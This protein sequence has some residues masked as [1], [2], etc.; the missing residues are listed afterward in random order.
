MGRPKSSRNKRPSLQSRVDA[1]T[2]RVDEATENLKKACAAVKIAKEI[3]QENVELKT[4]LANLQETLERER[5]YARGERDE[6]EKLAH[7]C[8]TLRADRF[9]SNKHYGEV[10]E[11]NIAL[12]K[13]LKEVL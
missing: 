12:R 13:A 4:T 9:S 11:Q 7:I 8:D 6:I 1:L 2:A 10:C 5:S 3:L